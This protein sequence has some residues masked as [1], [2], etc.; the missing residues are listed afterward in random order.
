MIN[1][2]ETKFTCIVNGSIKETSLTSDKPCFKTIKEAL[3][4][5]K[6][7]K[8]PS[9]F[10]K[11]GVYIEKIHIS[12][13]NLTIVGESAKETIIA[14]DDYAGK[15]DSSGEKLGTF[16]SATVTVHD[17]SVNF[18]LFNVTVKNT[19]DKH[20]KET[21]GEQAVALRSKA[22][23]CTYY[24]VIFEAFQDTLYLDEGRHYVYDCMISG[25][26]DFIFGG[27][28]VIFDVCRIVNVARPGKELHFGY[29]AAPRTN[30]DIEVL[31]Q[32]T[33]LGFL[34]RACHIT[35]TLN[36]EGVPEEKKTYLARPWRK[37]ARAVFMECNIADHI[38]K[39]RWTTMGGRKPEDA[40]FREFSNYNNT[41]DTDVL[42]DDMLEYYC[43]TPKV[44]FDNVPR[45]TSNNGSF[46]P[47]PSEDFKN[48]TE[49][50]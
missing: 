12:K 44:I 20:E 29:V 45:H 7:I 47:N 39:L 30:Y 42:E 21:S 11:N 25:D 19:W 24:K 38:S 35:S 15:F 14:Y 28:N 23:K 3:D 22:D 27:A 46:D 37:D 40:Y 41:V 43:S 17:E 10:I 5:V 6:N 2:N 48:Y 36:V 49:V 33:P 8:E 32:R 31:E 50:K 34:F 18:K 9:I 26:V 13:S 1:I 4:Y 16:R